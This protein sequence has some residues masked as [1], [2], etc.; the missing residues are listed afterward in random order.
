MRIVFSLLSLLVICPCSARA[1][2]ATR[3]LIFQYVSPYLDGDV[4]QSSVMALSPEQM[5]TAS[6][7]NSLFDGITLI[8]PWSKLE[9]RPGQIDFSVLDQ[10]LDFWGRK[11]KQVL[12]NISSVNFPTRLGKTWGGQLDNGTP[13]WVQ[14]QCE[15]H[16]IHVRTLLPLKETTAPFLMPVPWDPHFQALY[17]DFISRM[18]QR[19]DGD[20][21]LA[22]VRIGTG[23][24][25]EEQFLLPGVG[26]T[27]KKWYG[28]VQAT[29]RAYAAAFKKSPLECDLAW[30]GVAYLGT[31]TARLAEFNADGGDPVDVENTINLLK[32]DH[33]V[34]GN[35]GWRA[36]DIAA[37]AK[38]TAI[39]SLLHQFHQA[40]YP[41]A[42]E[43]GGPFQN[44]RMWGTDQLWSI[45]QSLRPRQDQLHGQHRR[46][47]QLRRG[48]SRSP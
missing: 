2:E 6:G 16:L 38:W 1:A 22:A 48:N 28:Y 43:V 32:Q 24:E 12:L 31:K 42:L 26:F 27:N 20:R 35:N 44:K 5:T 36:E 37:K 4:M 39:D 30:S 47:R 19:Y 18:G 46:D 25:G 29:I 7:E 23:M 11:G 15:T 8:I 33:I 14:Q 9:P 41:V 45:A 3:P 17:A 34:F 10:P 40:A 21:R 13:A